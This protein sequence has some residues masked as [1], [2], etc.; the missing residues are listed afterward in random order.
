MMISPEAYIDNIKDKS[1]KNL[2]KFMY[3]ILILTISF[4]SGLYHLKYQNDWLLL[5]DII[6]ILINREN[7]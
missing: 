7:L 2:L 5:K 4:T 1:Y 6:H 3:L